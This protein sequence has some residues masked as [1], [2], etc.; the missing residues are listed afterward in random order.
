MLNLLLSEKSDICPKEKEMRVH[1]WGVRGSLPAPQLPSEIKNKIS[2][3]LERLSPSDIESPESKERFL[4]GL[5]PGLFGTIGG[6]TPCISIDFGGGGEF[7]VFDSGSGTRDMGAVMETRNPKPDHYHIFYSHFHWDHIQG[8]PFFNPIYDPS[9]TVD[10]YSPIKNLK[11]ILG[12]QM[13]EPYFP[14]PLDA[15]MAQKTFHHMT[16][17]VLIHSLEISCKKMSHPG[18]SYSYLVNDGTHRFIYASDTELSAA[19]FIKNDENTVFFRDADVIVLDAQYTPWEAVEKINWGHSAFNTA[20]DFA[21]AWGIKHLVL[22]HHDPAHD[23]K[24]LFD[25]LQFARDYSKNMGKGL[26]ISL[27]VEGMELTL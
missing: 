9:V 23:D 21:A 25:I 13:R 1:F 7:L 22:F 18:D 19:D 8:L 14:I 15:V 12:G 27:A 3:I 2:C 26:E 17:K 4:A 24:K 6:N 11:T 20:V 10:F 16:G 5:S